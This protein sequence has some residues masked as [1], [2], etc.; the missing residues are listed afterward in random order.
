MRCEDALASLAGDRGL[1]R[2]L[3][4]GIRAANLRA[5]DRFAAL[6]AD[7]FVWAD[8]AG[9]G[10]DLLFSP[11]DYEELFLPAHAS[12]A[13]RCHDRG[14]IARLHSHGNIAKIMDA[15]VDAG[16]DIVHPLGPG[17]GNDLAAFKRRWGRRICL[18][19]GISR[20]IARMSWDEGVRTGLPGGKV[21]PCTESGIPAMPAARVDAF[22]G[23]LADSLERHRT[24]A[25]IG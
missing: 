14:T 13:A 4:G 18:N 2:E 1:V 25:A 7:G 21:M 17:D 9:S 11:R 16:I 5:I 22:V 24:L 3:V 10:L 20:F 6:G 8:D 15:V 19:G 23:Y 12:W